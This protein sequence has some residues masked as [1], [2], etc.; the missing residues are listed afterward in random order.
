LE[1]SKRMSE[2][3]GR[4]ANASPPPDLPGPGASL[5]DLIDSIPRQFQSILTDR[6][7]AF[8]DSVDRH[9]AAVYLWGDIQTVICVCKGIKDD[10]L[11]RHLQD[12]VGKLQLLIQAGDFGWERSQPNLFSVPDYV[13]PCPGGV[14]VS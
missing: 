12:A 7:P 9:I 3:S 8:F 1:T 11:Q 14:P 2:W 4:R 5:Q 6:S 13:K 10:A